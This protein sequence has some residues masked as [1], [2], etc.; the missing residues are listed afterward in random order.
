MTADELKVGVKGVPG[1]TMT[2]ADIDQLMLVMD[3][4]RNGMVDYTEFIA[5]CLQ[6]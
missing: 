2:D 4:N 3:S 6:S 1:C 5:G